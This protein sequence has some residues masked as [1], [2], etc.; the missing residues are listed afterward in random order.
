MYV[1]L[2]TCVFI[3]ICIYGYIGIYIVIIGNNSKNILINAKQKPVVER[4]KEEVD[5]R[6]LTE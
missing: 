3:Y 2:S 1:T 6:T 5:L 4:F